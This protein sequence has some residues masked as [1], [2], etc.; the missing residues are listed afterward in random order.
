MSIEKG[1]GGLENKSKTFILI[2]P[3]KKWGDCMEDPHLML[4]LYVMLGAVVAMVYGL[5][6][7]FLLE[8][9]ILALDKNILMI[10]KKISNLLESRKRT[11]GGKKK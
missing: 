1:S 6:R 4:I 2:N 10:D 5:R 7:I 3:L 11:K 8:R 9:K